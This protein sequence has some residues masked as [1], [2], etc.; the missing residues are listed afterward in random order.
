MVIFINSGNIGIGYTKN[1][2]ITEKLDVDGNLKCD[3]IKTTGFISPDGTEFYLKNTDKRALEPEEQITQISLIDD[4]HNKSHID[5]NFALKTELNSFDK[6]YKSLSDRPDF[7]TNFIFGEAFPLSLPQ[8]ELGEVFE[9]TP[10]FR[11]AVS[12]DGVSGRGNIHNN[13]MVLKSDTTPYIMAINNQPYGEAVL[14]LQVNFDD[15]IPPTDTQE[16]E[17]A[18]GGQI[19]YRRGETAGQFSG[20]YFRNLSSPYN[21]FNGFFTLPKE[22]EWTMV[23]TDSKNVGIGTVDPTEKLQVQGNIK[24]DKVYANSI[25]DDSG[26]EL[27]L[28]DTP[29]D[30]PNGLT[31]RSLSNYV[32]S[33][34]L[35]VVATSG[36]YNDLSSKPNL[37]S[38]SY[39][40]LT[41]KPNL[42]SGS[43][44]DLT[45]KPNLSIYLTSH[46]SLDNYYNK[47]E[48]DTQLTNINVSLDDIVNYE[49]H[50]IYFDQNN[51]SGGGILTHQYR[52]T[53]THEQI[54]G[55]ALNMSIGNPS[56]NIYVNDKLKFHNPNE[57]SSHNYHHILKNYTDD[58]L[59][60]LTDELEYQFD[61]SGTYYVLR[62]IN[63]IST[64]HKLS[65]QVL[66]KHILKDSVFS[67]NFYSKSEINSFNYLTSHQSLDNYYN[68]NQIDAF[69][70]LTTHQSL[71][72]YIQNTNG[73][74][75][76]QGNS[77]YGSGVLQL[78][79]ETN[80][81]GIKIK[82]PPHVAGANYTLT[83]PYSDGNVNQV[84]KTDGSG[85]LG[86]INYPTNYI[87]ISNPTVG[88]L[89]YDGSSY[90]FDNSVSSGGGSTDLSGITITEDSVLKL[91]YEKIKKPNTITQTITTDTTITNE[92]T[93]TYT[94]T[95]ELEHLVENITGEKGWIHVRHRHPK[96]GWYYGND[97]FQ[98][99]LNYG[100]AYNSSNEWS[101]PWTD[102]DQIFIVKNIQGSSQYIYD[103]ITNIVSIFSDSGAWRS[104][105]DI[106]SKTYYIYNNPGSSITGGTNQHSPYIALNYNNTGSYIFL[107]NQSTDRDDSTANFD[108]FVRK[109]T[110]TYSSIVS[111]IPL[112][113]YLIDFEPYTNTT[114][115]TNYINSLQ[116]DGLV[117]AYDLNY[118]L[119]S[120]NTDAVFK[121]YSH[122]GYIDFIIPSGYDTVDITYGFEGL[123][124]EDPT[125][126]R[127][128]NI[129]V[130]S[131]N[132]NLKQYTANNLVSGQII[133]ISETLG[134]M[135]RIIKL[136]Y[137]N[138]SPEYK[139]LTFQASPLIFTFRED[140]SPYSWQE[141]YDEAI[142]NGKRMP[143]K[144]EL[145]D[146]LSL[147]GNQPL[148]Q[149][150]A[151]CAV[152][153]PEYSNGRDYIHIG[154]HSTHFVG[155][156]HTADSGGYPW[157]GDQINTYVF[158]RFYCEVSGGD[159]YNE[160]WINWAK[161]NSSSNVRNKNWFLKATKPAGQWFVDGLLNDT[162]SNKHLIFIRKLANGTIQWTM[163][164]KSDI[165]ANHNWS[166]L[167]RTSDYGTF[168]TIYR[169]NDQQATGSHAPILADTG[170]IGNNSAF[171]YREEYNAGWHSG[172]PGGNE[173]YVLEEQD[174]SNQFQSTE[175]TVNFP[176]DTTV[177]INNGNNIT[178]NGNY[179]VSVSS[180]TSYINDSNSQTVYTANVNEIILKYSM[181][182]STT[183]TT[184]VIPSGYL[185][186]DTSLNNYTGGWDVV[187]NS[188]NETLLNKLDLLYWDQGQIILDIQYSYNN[189][190]WYD[191][192][193]GEIINF[194]YLDPNS[195]IQ[196]DNAFTTIYFRLKRCSITNVYK[197]HYVFSYEDYFNNYDAWD[198]N[199]TTHSVLY[200][201][202]TADNISHHTEETTITNEIK[203]SNHTPFNLGNF[204]FNSTHPD[205]KYRFFA[206]LNMQYTNAPTTLRLPQIFLKISRM[207]Y[208]NKITY[209]GSGG[210]TGTI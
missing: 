59:V 71:S 118:I 58:L 47:S 106:Q 150:D 96:S 137:Y 171:I 39:I 110:D 65:I 95:Q 61:T 145:L 63:N 81:H 130:D 198:S 62:A 160:T 15:F 40:D 195:Q 3:N 75:I 90:V 127:I 157:W 16:Q 159:S 210:N 175:Y 97:N 24:C 12:G 165:S 49:T 52:N 141:A 17:N 85:N 208:I 89:K 180:S 53:L 168:S 117:Q 68:K 31:R 207:F 11:F 10:Y 182:T 142:A 77:T 108:I 21:I 83:L 93:L 192:E 20:L 206:Y 45:S 188:E 200:I 139:N 177:N 25:I 5:T 38:G 167:S 178:F 148:Y 91:D 37:F 153:A 143:T 205:A 126:I 50:N 152:V 4:Y 122:L 1:H 56:I 196:P 30:N 101:I 99:N 13:A 80:N 57:Q 23:L 116:T 187:S 54:S 162:P 172:T 73:S 144:T 136:F 202:T 9:E 173:Y 169:Y 48:I 82:G 121:S 113:N 70:F 104:R 43:Y 138:T 36:S 27:F 107:E 193:Q 18:F 132:L 111:V 102:K 134:Q 74:I 146:Y 199:N 69:N 8:G 166:S 161:F 22:D 35:H 32:E 19:G 84:L 105:T 197:N 51:Y 156:S 135:N 66:E 115:W 158:K 140:E 147:N 2:N 179:S 92:P 100:T 41:S 64:S 154:N 119:D 76:V 125:E 174:D 176:E 164:L 186:Y 55:G 151:W 46:Q 112:P 26:V 209:G 129:L 203:E 181:R 44:N 87:Q 201:I 204:T 7:T 98:G 163:I 194:V 33:T 124:G 14:N 86:W 28:G 72:G 185:K 42:F 94:P 191:V 189:T 67:D 149:E 120:Y 88:Y 190:N 78:N 103:N 170:S 155:K 79:C 123:T 131:T 109:S 34:S 114:T 183:T 133:R 184:Q 60:N 29:D 128:N 6:S